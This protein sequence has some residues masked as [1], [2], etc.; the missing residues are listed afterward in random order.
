MDLISVPLTAPARSQLLKARTV[1]AVLSVVVLVMLEASIAVGTALAEQPNWTLTAILGVIA[2]G[3]TSAFS[4]RRVAH[5]NRDLN[6]GTMTRYAGPWRE[7]LSRPLRNSGFLRVKVPGRFMLLRS[8]ARPVITDAIE[9][10]NASRW[11][12]AAGH[13]EYA[14]ASRLLLNV[15]RSG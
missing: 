3:A 15:Q 10:G 5:L 4:V 2:L 7:Q 6:S 14:T 12:R 13:L 1:T 11:S 9:A 8:S